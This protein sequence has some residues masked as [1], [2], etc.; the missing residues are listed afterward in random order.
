MC[1][2]ICQLD[3]FLPVS[4][5]PF[6]RL[7]FFHPE[8]PLIIRCINEFIRVI[9]S[10]LS[11]IFQK[12][13]CFWITSAFFTPCIQSKF[14]TCKGIIGISIFLCNRNCSSDVHDLFYRYCCRFSSSYCN[15]FDLCT[16]DITF[17]C[18]CLFYIVFTWIQFWKRNNSFTVCNCRCYFLIFL[19]KSAV[20]RFQDFCRI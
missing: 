12:L 15:I 13:S 5:I 14:C 17:G 16:E 8:F 1:T 10:C 2:C 4:C 18:F 20:S 3:I 7:R 9:A 11:I 19:I 6:G